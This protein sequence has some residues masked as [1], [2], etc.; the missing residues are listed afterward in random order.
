MANSNQGRTLFVS[1]AAQQA[2]LNQTQFE[3]L[4]WVEVGLMG[5]MG[6]IGT[7]TNI[8]TYD[9]WSELVVQKAKG[10]SNAGDPT[11]EVARSFD[12]P[13]Q[14]ILRTIALTNLNYAFYVEGNDI[15][16]PGGSGTIRYLRGL[17]VGPTVPQGRNE[18]FDLEIFTL[19]LQQ[20]QVVVDPS[21]TP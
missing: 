2:D 7:T 4:T 15:A 5:S 12:D 17:C 16:E 19:A 3:A 13:G 21:V 20:F 8:L 14:V 18:D 1:A 11:I 10:Q 6:E 9:T